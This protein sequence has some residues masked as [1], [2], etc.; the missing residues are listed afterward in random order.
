[1]VVVKAKGKVNVDAVMKLMMETLEEQ[2][3]PEARKK[4]E[5]TRKT[6]GGTTYLTLPKELMT[7]PSVDSDMLM[8]MSCWEKGFGFGFGGSR[9]SHGLQQGGKVGSV[10]CLFEHFG[11]GQAGHLCHER[12]PSV[13]T[14][15]A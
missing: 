3:G 8:S 15:P 9:Q 5:S 11:Q 14:Q 7:D 13:W 1:M 12:S 2:E 10:L 4:L 6:Q